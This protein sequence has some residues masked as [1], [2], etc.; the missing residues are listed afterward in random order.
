MLL[1]VVLAIPLM[2][3]VA[4][5]AC[6]FATCSAPFMEKGWRKLYTIP[7]AVLAWALLYYGHMWWMFLI[8]SMP[9]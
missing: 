4:G 5:V 1:F 2:M 9:S 8:T 7:L 6:I 3:M